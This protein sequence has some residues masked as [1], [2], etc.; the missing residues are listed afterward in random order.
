MKNLDKE[1]EKVEIMTTPLGD[2][3]PSD[4]SIR[5]MAI[6]VTNA[7]KTLTETAK[8]L[9]QAQQGA[10]GLLKSALVKLLAQTK[11]SQE[12]VDEIKAIT[13]EQRERVQVESILK[14]ARSRIDKVDE[15]FQKVAEAEVPYLKGMDLLPLEEATPAVAAC[16]AAGVVV[17]QAIN[18][19]RAFLTTKTLEIRACVASVSKS[20]LAEV[21]PL[22]QRIE[23]H[24]EKLSQFK[25]DTEGRKRIAQTQ[26][27]QAKVEA[28]EEAIQKCILATAPLAAQNVDEMTPEEAADTMDKL[29]ESD[30]FAQSKLDE[31]RKFVSDRQR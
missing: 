29:G 21:T 13:Q 26:E 6:A 1:I 10:Q 2:E 11:K 4:E 15:A 27:A 30:Q 23:A 14:E 17:Q 3:R 24:V 12:K 18:D 16:E 9:D 31:A 7:Q 5:E 8:A 19:A 28:A 25:Q 22:T 20:G